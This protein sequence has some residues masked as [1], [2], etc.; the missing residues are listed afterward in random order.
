MGVR[1]LCFTGSRSTVHLWLLLCTC[2]LFFCLASVGSKFSKVGVSPPCRICTV[3]STCDSGPGMYNIHDIT[4]VTAC[5]C[6]NNNDNNN[7]SSD[8]II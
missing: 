1:A 4:I 8:A 6:S 3:T 7:N 2:I 5:N